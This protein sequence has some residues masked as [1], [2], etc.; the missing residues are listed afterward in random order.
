MQQKAEVFP[1]PV[2]LATPKRWNLLEAPRQSQG[3]HWTELTKDLFTNTIQPCSTLTTGDFMNVLVAD[4]DGTIYNHHPAY[5]EFLTQLEHF[6][7]R[8]GLANSQQMESYLA[9]LRKKHATRSATVALAF[10]LQVPVHTI[11]RELY[12]PLLLLECHLAPQPHV[13]AHLHKLA[14]TNVL[15]TNSVRVH[16]CRVLRETQLENSFLYTICVDDIAPKS[17]PESEAFQFVM[18]LFPP[19]T[20][21]TLIDDKKENLLAAKALGWK[22]ILTKEFHLVDADKDDDV[23]PTIRSLC[24]LSPNHF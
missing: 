6:L 10:E 24:E 8:R 18:S 21:F 19:D 20:R 14:M 13:A 2:I 7:L 4:L 15:F 9:Q 12:T 17:K 5:L 11:A 16:A 3:I 1:D 23:F 22:G